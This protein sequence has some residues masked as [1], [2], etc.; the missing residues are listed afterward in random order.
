MVSHA[1][2]MLAFLGASAGI[3]GF[4]LV[5]LGL[6]SSAIQAY[7]PGTPAVVLRPLREAA[8]A[9]VAV[10]GIS[11]VATALSA[12]WLLTDDQQ[13]VYVVSVVAFYVQLVGL[14][15]AVVLVMRRTVWS[16]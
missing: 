2:V 13:F 5:F 7:D 6:L 3:G 15:S 8:A 10:F 14:V 11:L 1:N 12:T 4:T 16:G 9:V